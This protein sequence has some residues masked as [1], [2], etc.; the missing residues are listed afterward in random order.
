MTDLEVVL[1]WSFT[2]MTY[3]WFRQRSDIRTLRNIIID[4]G[5]KE[6]RVEIDEESHVVRIVR[7]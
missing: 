4:I 7:N 5:H 3:M 2:F 6:A 1:L